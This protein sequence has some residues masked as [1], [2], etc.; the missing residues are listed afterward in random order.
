M[1]VP[2]IL[3]GLLSRLDGRKPQTEDKR[4]QALL[5]AREQARALFAEIESLGLIRAGLSESQ[6]SKEI[7]K[8]SRARFGAGRHW[9][10]RI[11]RAGPNTI[12]PYQIDPEDRIIEAGDIVYLDLG[13]VFAEWE[14]DFGRT[15]VLGDDPDK[16]EIRR[17]TEETFREVKAHFLA[18]PDITGS[19]LYD[20]AVATVDRKGRDFGNEHAGHLVGEF[21]HERIPDDRVSLYIHPE[22]RAPLRGCDR[23]GRQRHWILEIH[24]VDRERRYGAFVE[25]LLTLG[26]ITE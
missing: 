21:P 15:Y 20:F 8:L 9:H 3:T 11:L 17:Q 14:A 16:L 18:Y 22:N 6:A 10:K 19:A 7:Y 25:D 23:L 12:H 24:L 26:E 4:A 2:T 1:R 5:A 13:P